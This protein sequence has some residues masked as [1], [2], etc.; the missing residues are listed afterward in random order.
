MKISNPLK[1]GVI[2]LLVLGIANIC[3]ESLA[4]AL[5]Y[6]SDAAQ[7]GFSDGIYTLGVLTWVIYQGL[8]DKYGSL[9]TIPTEWLFLLMLSSGLLSIVGLF[10]VIQ[11]WSEYLPYVIKKAN[12][13]GYLL[14]AQ[15][16]ILMGTIDGTPFFM[17]LRT[18]QALQKKFYE[19]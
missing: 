10:D 16:S 19:M 8:Q 9:K 18:A 1:Y 14:F 5:A 17:T 6:P 13:L 11:Y 12:L 15:L 4:E 3:E 7:D 2:A